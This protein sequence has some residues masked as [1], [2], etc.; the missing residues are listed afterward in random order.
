MIPHDSTAR[1][2]FKTQTDLQEVRVPSLGAHV[3]Q[4]LPASLAAGLASD[5]R[6][7]CFGCPSTV[8]T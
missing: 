5:G 8:Q 3:W 1:V 7:G 6:G 2:P 4:S